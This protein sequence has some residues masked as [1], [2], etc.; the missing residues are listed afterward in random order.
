M[1]TAPV[2]MHRHT[3]D[4]IERRTRSPSARAVREQGFCSVA[5][6]VV[7]IGS[8]AKRLKVTPQT[9]GKWRARFLAH[10]MHGLDG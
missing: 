1:S 6:Q 2:R 5:T 7:Q 8:A 10:G 9:V 4:S 3:L